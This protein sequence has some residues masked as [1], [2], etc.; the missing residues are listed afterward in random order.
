MQPDS[1]STSH[2]FTVDVEEYFH[3]RALEDVVDRG[4][5][6]DRPSRV[7]GSIE[8]LLSTLERHD[9][10]GTFFV[11]GWLAK[12]RPE[13]VRAITSRGHEIA[14]H[15]FFHDP[16]TRLDPDSF[17][18]DARA[19]KQTIEDLTGVEVAGYRAP[20]FSI[21][22]GLEWAFDV[23]VEEGYVYDSSLFPIRRRGYGYPNCPRSPHCIQTKAGSLFEF[24]LATTRLLGYPIP[25]AGGGYLRQFPFE[26]IRRAFR[27]ASRAGV[28][29]TF[30]I[31]PW[32][33]DG[34]QPR[35][36]VP[37]LTHIR[38]YRGLRTSL[39]RIERLLS[40]F[41]FTT[42]E[43]YLCQLKDPLASRAAAGVA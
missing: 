13:V 19:A 42:I 1:H 35:L 28:P 15:G 20:N 2:F 22:P 34:E 11:L 30:Y 6:L 10:R 27:E 37:P 40:E 25:A 24:P 12:H 7:G 3:V 4:G 5:W 17:R 26:V 36:R 14:S 33:I 43:S 32:E 18:E 9:A 31:H 8:R 38:H 41:R 16:V 23:L 21:I 39:A 29:A